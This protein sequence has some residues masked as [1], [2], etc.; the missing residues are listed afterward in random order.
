MVDPGLAWNS[1]GGTNE[2]SCRPASVLLVDDRPAN[3]VALEATLAPLGV[4][5]VTAVSGPEALRR[6]L[7]EEFALVLLDVQMPGMDGFETATL[8]KRHPRT[9][10]VPVIFVT[11][12]HREPAHLFRGYER[13]AVDYLTKP[14][15]PNILRSKVRVFVDI[16]VQWFRV[17]DAA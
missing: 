4:R 9:A 12:I 5:T 14:F 13:G 8:M 3:L 1:G 7:A 15:D 10:H 6:L 2:A 16:L 17:R 11:A